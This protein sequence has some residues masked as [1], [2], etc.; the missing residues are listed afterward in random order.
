[1]LL[2]SVSLPFTT[3]IKLSSAFTS[4]RTLLVRA[5]PLYFHLEPSWYSLYD[6]RC[7][8]IYLDRKMVSW[9]DQQKPCCTQTFSMRKN[10]QVVVDCVQAEHHSWDLLSIHASS[11]YLFA[12][13]FAGVIVF[14][15]SL[16]WTYHSMVSLTCSSNGLKGCPSRSRSVGVASNLLLK[17]PG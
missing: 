9:L 15:Q 11:F 8:A 4:S 1:M 17:L 13:T 6:I 14:A 3:L 2:W 12:S 10:F 5:N 7:P 16:R